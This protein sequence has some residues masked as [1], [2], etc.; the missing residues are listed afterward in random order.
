MSW[1]ESQRDAWRRVPVDDL[2]YLDAADLVTMSDAELW[3]LVDEAWCA[4]YGG[5]RN[6]GDAWVRGLNLDASGRTVLDFGCGLGLDAA[7]LGLS[8]NRVVLADLNPETLRLADR[9]MSLLGVGATVAGLVKVSGDWPYV[10]PPVPV[11]SVLFSGVL[12]HLPYAPSV[13]RRAAQLVGSGGELRA[14]VYGRTAAERH[15]A[16][17][18]RAMDAVGEF[19]DWYDADRLRSWFGA[20]VEVVEV[21]SIGDGSY[22]TVH[23]VAR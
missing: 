9:V 20:W 14:M 11:D 12:H 4:R 5:W 13:V 2:G 15:G 8:G 21:V 1:F 16:D 7:R 6:Q 23:M 10:T 22:L 17:F 3:A 19:A 18:V